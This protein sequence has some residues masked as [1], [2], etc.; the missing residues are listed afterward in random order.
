MKEFGD[1]AK[2]LRKS[3][4]SLFKQGYAVR[5]RAGRQAKSHCPRFLCQAGY[6]GHR[7]GVEH[8]LGKEEFGD[9]LPRFS[10]QL[11]FPQG[12]RHFFF[13]LTLLRSEVT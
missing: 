1:K 6:E 7:E 10:S 3:S 12:R 8:S 4:E 13:Y 9:H 2:R 5:G 11:H